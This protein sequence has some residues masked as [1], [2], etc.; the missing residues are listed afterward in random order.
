MYTGKVIGSVVA[1]V[2]D[3]ALIGIKL[4]VVQVYE[5]GIAG[6]RIVAADAAG[7]AGQGDF[8]YL[9]GSREAG[10]ALGKG[11]MPVDAGIVGF[12][13]EYNVGKEYKEK[14]G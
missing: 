9:I 7:T 12:I 14:E 8:V 11:L 6:R 4:L 5:N 10:M 13:D 2:K 1:T 3:E